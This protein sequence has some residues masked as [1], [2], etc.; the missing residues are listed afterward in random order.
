MTSLALR[1]H[2]PIRVLDGFGRA[3]RAACRYAAPRD[4]G[5]LVDL[6][7]RARREGVPVTLRGAGRSYG[8]AALGAGGLVVDTSRLD[9]LKSWDPTT[10]VLDAEAGMTIE[11]VWRRTIEDGYWPHVVPG[12]MRP[13]LAGCLSMNVHGK[14]NAKAGPFGEHVLDF[15]LVT[16]ARGLLRCSRD[17][18]RDLFHAAIGGLGLLGA[19][20]RVRLS[21]KRVESG[22]LCVTAVAARD[23]EATFDAFEEE[24]ERSDYTVGWIDGLARGRSLGRGVLHAARYL[25]AGEDPERARSLHVESQVLPPRA[26]LLP[27][28]ALYRFMRPVMNDPGVRAINALKWAASR[29]RG[30]HTY[31]QSHVAFAFLLDYVP[32]WRLAYGREGFIQFQVFVPHAAAREAIAGVLGATHRHALPTYLAVLK[33]HRPDGFLLSH[34]LD[35]WSLAMDLRVHAA[36]RERLRAL[37][38]ELAARVLDAGGTFYLAKDAVL[39]P[40]DLARAYGPERLAAFADLRA[41]VDPDGSLTSD[42]ARRL[43]LASPRQREDEAAGGGFTPLAASGPPERTT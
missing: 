13:T 39:R 38:D 2:A 19:I 32:N 27:R 42:L 29:A 6:L 25:G 16:P 41:R 8:D 3:A 30:R 26:L 15:D 7:A 28:S 20:T 5:E 21:L 9:A 4:A 10:G 35:G 11:G 37:T 36:E 12:T 31:L 14:N 22:R 33:R 40:T 1:A 17:E 43:D 34:G 23:L 24:L 18:N